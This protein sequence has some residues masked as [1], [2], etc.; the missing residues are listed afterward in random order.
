MSKILMSMMAGAFALVAGSAGAQSPAPADC[1]AML[2]KA[3]QALGEP[4]SAGG[5]PVGYPGLADAP[6]CSVVFEGDGT[7]FGTSFGVVADKLAAMLRADGW[8]EDPDAAAD[9]PNGTAIGYRRGGQLAVMSVNVDAAPGACP[10]DEPWASCQ[11]A[12]QALQYRI[13]IDLRAAE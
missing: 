12:P 13:S 7:V 5:G 6:G 2:A 10:E 4:G 9:G 8:V 3:E 11:P 1:G